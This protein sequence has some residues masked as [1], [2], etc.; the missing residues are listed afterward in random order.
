[1]PTLIDEVRVCR[2]RT[3]D[4]PVLL[5]PKSLDR[6]GSE[7]IL[8]LGSSNGDCVFRA[9]PIEMPHLSDSVGL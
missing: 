9:F 6:A 1:M 3:R 4:S 7:H 8:S 2:L 5:P